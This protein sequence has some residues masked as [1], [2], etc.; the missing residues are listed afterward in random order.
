MGTHKELDTDVNVDTNTEELDQLISMFESNNVFK[1]AVDL[2]KKFRE[3]IK[4]GSERGAYKIADKTRAFQELT[5]ALNGNLFHEKLINSI[6]VEK[7]TETRYLVGTT[8][9]HFYPLC[10]EFGRKKVV[11]KNRKVLRWH[12]LSGNVVFAKESKAS[13]PYPFVKPTYERM[14]GGAGAD[15]LKEEIYNATN[16]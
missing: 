13:K 7:K 15:I 11:P 14:K 12:T 9:A 1:P 10:V 8:I 16:G 2:A 4:K 5:I 3:G 6:E